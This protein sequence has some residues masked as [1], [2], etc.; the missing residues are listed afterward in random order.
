MKN[1]VLVLFVMAHAGLYAQIPNNTFDTWVEYEGM[2]IPEGWEVNDTFCCTFIEKS[3][4][5]L[6]GDHALKV[7]IFA[8]H[9]FTTEWSIQ[10]T[11]PV[12]Q[13][14]QY[15]TGYYRIDSIFNMGKARI[16]IYQH[17]GNEFEL[18]ANKEFPEVSEG[19]EVFNIGFA[20][21]ANADSIRIRITTNILNLNQLPAGYAE[22]I[23]DQLELSETPLSQAP[24]ERINENAIMLYPNPF[25][26]NLN[27]TFNYPVDPDD[28]F[29]EVYDTHGKLL[30]VQYISPENEIT[31][32]TDLPPGMYYLRISN[33]EGL[34]TVKQVTRSH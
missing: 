25:T 3:G 29:V 18:I 4:F 14:Y 16:D 15:L 11:F 24:V 5:S 34:M 30:T 9:H 6:N 20:Q 12:N 19:F 26:D 22:I 28:I 31:G 32:I 2:E 10:T 7:Y 1:L 27:I 8:P 23:L 13:A 21:A 17:V 33:P